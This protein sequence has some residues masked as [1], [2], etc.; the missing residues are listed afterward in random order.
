MAV[1]GYRPV[2]RKSQPEP[3]QSWDGQSAFQQ[4]TS[5]HSV[6]QQM[7]DGV[8]AA[9]QE[10]PGAQYEET[11]MTDSQCLSLQA[12]EAH[13]VA[14]RMSADHQKFLYQNWE[15]EGGD[16]AESQ[17]DGGSVPSHLNFGNAGDEI[18]EECRSRISFYLVLNFKLGILTFLKSSLH[19]GKVMW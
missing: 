17:G 18:S 3:Q 11:Q 8:H 16:K 15:Q 2:L 13:S 5:T 9:L 14:Q 6:V 7:S 10:V 19:T 4:I 1:H 12:S